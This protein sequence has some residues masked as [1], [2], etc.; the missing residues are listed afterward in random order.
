MFG[1]FQVGL[2][3]VTNYVSAISCLNLSFGMMVM[4]TGLQL[5]TDDHLVRI[6]EESG[7]INLLGSYLGKMCGNSLE[8]VFVPLSYVLGF[9]SN[10][11]SRVGMGHSLLTFILLYMAITGLA[12]LVS[13]SFTVSAM[14]LPPYY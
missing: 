3:N 5:F 7:G 14:M 4:A 2:N 10:A 6:R 13:A 11:E 8:L 12:N 9:W 1:S